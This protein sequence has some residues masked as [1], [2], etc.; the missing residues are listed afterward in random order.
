MVLGYLANTTE[1]YGTNMFVKFKKKHNLK[2]PLE[3]GTLGPKFGVYKETGYQMFDG[4]VEVQRQLLKEIIPEKYLEYFD[5]RFAVINSKVIVPHIDE[6]LLAINFYIQTADATTSFYKIKDLT[7]PIKYIKGTKTSWYHEEELEFIDSFHANP[8]DIWM[9][10]TSQIHGVV[11][12]SPVDRIAYTMDTL[13]IT[14]KELKEILS[15]QLES[16]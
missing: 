10:D 1:P 7:A 11:C 5:C 9:L 15:D 4:D 13:T 14:F 8:G 16:Y 2:I 12:S 3:L 6:R